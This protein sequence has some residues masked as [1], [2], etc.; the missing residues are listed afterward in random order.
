MFFKPVHK[1]RWGNDSL[2]SGLGSLPCAVVVPGGVQMFWAVGW[3]RWWCNC[4]PRP[5]AGSAYVV[6]QAFLWAFIFPMKFL[7]CLLEL[8]A[9]IKQLFLRDIVYVCWSQKGICRHYF[10]LLKV[11]AEPENEMPLVLF[12]PKALRTNSHPFWIYTR[13][14]DKNRSRETRGN[15]R[16]W[17]NTQE[18]ILSL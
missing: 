1:I 3:Q 11:N 10:Y 8:A 4:S 6:R 2:P 5:S 9:L 15:V 16:T 14:C 13:S 17:E 12:H 18:K 7:S